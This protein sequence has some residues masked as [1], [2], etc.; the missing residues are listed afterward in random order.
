MTT[1]AEMDPTSLADVVVKNL[2][3][4]QHHT[5]VL[6]LLFIR[7]IASADGASTSHSSVWTKKLSSFFARPIVASGEIFSAPDVNKS[8]VSLSSVAFAKTK[9]IFEAILVH[10]S[11]LSPKKV[12]SG[13]DE[14]RG[15]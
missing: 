6:L 1:R 4:T 11:S 10:V 9:S 3:P 5:L 13:I 14:T 8:G 2:P 7:D 12:A 15:R